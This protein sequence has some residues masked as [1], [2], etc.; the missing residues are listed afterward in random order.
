M[1]STLLPLVEGNETERRGVSSILTKIGNGDMLMLDEKLL[2]ESRFKSREQSTT[3]VPNAIR[4]FHRSRDVEEYNNMMFHTPGVI[5]CVASH[6]L[7]GY[8]TT[9]RW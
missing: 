5:A 6:T 2:L 1:I 3:D 7:C 4:S 9:N 8:K